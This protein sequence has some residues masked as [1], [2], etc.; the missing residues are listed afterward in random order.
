MTIH[1][2]HL[3]RFFGVVVVPD[4]DDDDDY[5]GDYSSSPPRRRHYEMDCKEMMINRVM[6][7]Y[8]LRIY[9]ILLF[10]LAAH[11]IVFPTWCIFSF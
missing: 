3:R 10:A 11:Y 7:G 2:H 1:H 8:K 5:D 4:D 6:V 9:R